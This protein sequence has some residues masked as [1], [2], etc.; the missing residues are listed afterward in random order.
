MSMLR[1]TIDTIAIMR[2]VEL[3]SRNLSV[4]EGCVRRYT[5]AHEDC[6]RIELNR[7]RVPPGQDPRRFVT[8]AGV[9]AVAE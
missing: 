2:I 9:Q 8:A 5:L 4:A 3:F 7:F 1:K 6:H